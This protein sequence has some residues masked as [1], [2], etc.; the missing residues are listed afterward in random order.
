MAGGTPAGPSSAG[1]PGSPPQE[2]PDELA[3]LDEPQV[4]AQ[5]HQV[6]DLRREHAPAE[7]RMPLPDALREVVAQDGLGAPRL[8]TL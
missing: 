4:G 6:L 2:V 8:L 1:A 7:L 5:V 3:E